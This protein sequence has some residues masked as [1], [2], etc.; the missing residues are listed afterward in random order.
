[1]YMYNYIY[2]Y[3]YTNI[4]IYIQKIH[5]C[6]NIQP[7]CLFGSHGLHQLRRQRPWAAQGRA[8]GGHRAA[9]GAQAIKEPGETP[10]IMVIGHDIYVCL[11]IHMY[12]YIYI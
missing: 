10:W 1:M 2:V 5:T 3:T 4:Y 7:C 11:Y 9:E 8:V 12:V 6:P